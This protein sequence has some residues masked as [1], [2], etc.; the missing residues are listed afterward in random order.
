MVKTVNTDVVVRTVGT[1][2]NL[3][4]QTERDENLSIQVCLAFGMEKIFKYIP[5]HIIAN[6]LGPP[7]KSLVLPIFYALTGYDTVSRFLW[8]REKFAWDTWSVCPTLTDALLSLANAPDSV[9]DE[10]LS[11]IERFHYSHVHQNM[12]CARHQ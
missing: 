11:E 8:N 10:L 12:P 2:E 4:Q 5:A 1:M 6:S 7:H 9:S 3:K